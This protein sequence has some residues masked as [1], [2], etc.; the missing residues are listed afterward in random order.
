[1]AQTVS[2]TDKGNGRYEIKDSDGQTRIVDFATAS[3]E[4]SKSGL[5]ISTSGTS[6]LP[7][8]TQ[9][10]NPTGYSYTFGQNYPT[11]T[12]QNVPAGSVIINGRITNAN[13]AKI[14]RAHV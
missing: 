9:T 8:P 11:G 10:S 7:S 6:S 5:K 14:G 1:M 4:A 2:I 3:K 13:D 12:A